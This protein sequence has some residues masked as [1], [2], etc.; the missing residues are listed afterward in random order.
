MLLVSWHLGELRWLGLRAAAPP[1][2]DPQ[3]EA[4]A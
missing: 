4:R 1:I 3:L 2:V